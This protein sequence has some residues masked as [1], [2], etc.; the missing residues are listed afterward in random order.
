MIDIAVI[1]SGA[2]G[3]SAAVNCIARNRTVTV[4]G[5]KIETSMLYKAERVDNHL[6]MPSLTG[7][8]MLESFLEH[9]KKLNIKIEEGRIIQILPMGKYFSLNFENKMFVETKTVILATGISKGKTVSGE[10]EYLGKGV[11]YCAT[12]DGMLYKNK[13]VVLYSE[14]EEG[15]ADA[16]FLADICKSV[17]FISEKEP[18][19]DL[20]EKVTVIQGKPIEV[21]GN[22]FVESVKVNDKIIK[23]EGAFFIKESLPMDSLIPNLE[24]KDNAI[25]VNRFMETNLKGVFACGDCT[26]WPYQVSN[27]VGEG[28]ISAQRADKLIRDEQL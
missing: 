26:G 27:A 23:C 10:S 19:G 21:L 4:F 16:N 25:V 20:H 6:G 15:I 8:E 22:D 13:D 11:S 5:R 7:K 3:L 28:L 18:K 14:I 17:T 1:G 2:A 9:T 24:L 12:C